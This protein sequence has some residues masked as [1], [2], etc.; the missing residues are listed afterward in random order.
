[1]RGIL[2][3]A[4]AICLSLGGARGQ[5]SIR[6]DEPGIRA[7]LKNESTTISVPIESKL[8][9]SVRANLSL[10]WI[11]MDD[12]AF[13]SAVRDISIEPGRTSVE[14]PLPIPESSLW[15]RLE[16]S[17]VPDRVDARAF[18][19]QS[20]VVALSQIAEHVFEL[21]A[22][23]VGVRHP[24]SPFTIHAQAVHPLTRLPIRG[25][26]WDARL[27]L[28]GVAMDPVKIA[29][30]VQGFVEISFEVPAADGGDGTDDA[31]LWVQASR[32]D[33]STSV[34]LSSP[35]ADRISARIQTDKP[36]YQPG[37]T[38]HLRAVVLD[39]RGRALAGARVKLQIDD[40]E[41]STEHTARLVASRFGVIQ[42]DWTLGTSAGLG[43]YQIR[44]TTE[45]DGYQIAN[46]AVRISRYELPTF[47]VTAKPDR[48]AYLPGQQ[49][50]VSISG[51]Y[52]FGKPVPRGRV[53]L[54]QSGG[55]RFNPKTRK[56]EAVNDTVAEGEAAADGTF[57]ANLDLTEDHENL[58]TDEN[59]RFEDL[60]FA[61]Y[62][63][64]PGSGRTEQRRFDVRITRGPIHIYLIRSEAGG[65]L[66]A[67]V[68]VSTDYADGAPASTTVELRY[69]GQVA[70]LHTNRYGLG[71]ASILAGR[72]DSG[73]LEARATD[74]AGQI[75][76]WTERYWSRGLEHLRLETNR[77]LYRSGE[78][79]TV[80]ISAP[81]HEVTAEFVMLHAIAGDR[82][83]ASRIVQLVD[84]K[85]QVTIP[86]QAEFRRTVVFV[87]WNAADAHSVYGYNVLGS[88]AVVFPDTSDLRLTAAAERT[89]YRPGEKATLR[90]QV[91][92]SDGRPVE[93]ALGLA[94]VD[95]AVLDRARTDSDFGHRTWFACA[96]CPD[97]GESEVGGIRLN[98][99]YALKPTTAI[100]PEMDLAAEALVAGTGG[101]IRTESS[102]SV[103]DAPQFK[104]VAS[105]LQ[106]M[107]DSLDR[108]YARTLEFPRD[109][110]ALAQVLGQQWSALRDPW[111]VRYEI[112]FRI[113]RNDNVIEFVSCGPDKRVG[114]QDDFVAGTLRRSYFAPLETLIKQILK[115]QQ[116]YPANDGE[117]RT[118]LS[119]NGLLLDSLRDPWSTPYR[120]SI[121]TQGVVRYITLLSAG[122]DRRFAS[123]DDFVAA[124]FSGRYFERE[125]AEIERALQAASSRPRTLEDFQRVLEKAGVDVSQYRDAW[126]RP[127]RLTSVRSSR[128]GDKF[129]STTVR[130]FGGPAVPRTNITPVTQH[131]ITFVLRSAGPDGVEDTYDDFDIARFVTLLDEESAAAAPGTPTQ[132]AGLLPGRGAVTGTISDPSGAV[133][134]AARVALIDAAQQSYETDSGADGGYLFSSVPTGVYSLRVSA[135]GF[136]LYEVSQVPVTADKA[137][138]VDI[139]LQVGAATEMVTVNAE[140]P[141]LNTEASLLAAPP[142]AT[143]RVREYFPETL[144]WMPEIITDSHGAARTQFALADSVTTWKVAAIASTLDGRVVEA[145]SDFRSFQPFFLDFNPPQVLTEGDRVDLPVTV[146]NYQD[147]ERK[148]GVNIQAN[149]WSAVSGS[150][151]KEL[152]VPANSSANVNYTIEARGSDDAARERI[153]AVAGH[154]RDAIEKTLR[155]HPDGQEVTQVRG[156]LIAGRTAFSV[157]IPPA[158][159][160]GAT[161]GELRLYPNIASM[162]LESAGAILESPHGCAEQTISAGYA[163][164]VALRYAR[165]AG[166]NDP[167]VEKRALTNIAEARDGLS[168]FRSPD[169]SVRYWPFGE[170]DIGVTAYALSFLVD[171]SEVVPVDRD[172][173]QSLVSWL[174]KEQ[175]KDGRWPP[176]L[177]LTGLVVRS[178]AAAQKT[179]VQVQA[180]VMA[181]AYHHIAQFTDQT[182]EP[183]LL[184]QFILAAMDSGDEALLGAAAP[185]LAAMAREEKGGLYWE[186][187]TNSPFYG[188]GTAGRFE[189][190]GLVVSALSAWRARHLEST[191]LDPVIR[192]GL[193]F[194]LRGRDRFGSWYST[195]STVRAMRAMADASA[196][197]GKFGGG[198]GRLEVRANGR[199]VKTVA[200]P[201]DPRTI[202]PI[203][204]DLSVALAAGDT[205]FEFLPS[206]GAQSALMRFSSTHWLPWTQTEARR[207]GELRLN[208]QFDGLETRAGEPLRC[209]VRAER[210]GF[211]GYGMMIAEIGL[212]PGAEVDRSSLESVLNDTS[213]GVN[214]YDVLPD[215]VLFYLWP[216]AG[217]AAFEF[218]LRGRITLVGKSAASVLYDYYNP[219][220]LAEV[221]PFRWVVK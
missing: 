215:R 46:H 198:G 107:S 101:F 92:S 115:S 89:V 99:L 167:R 6:I 34:S 114:T 90:M 144:L 171:A 136:K 2:F 157:T 1:M 211:R 148:V 139:E 81:P 22:T 140:A 220:A 149:A 47:N 130:V 207:S 14:I 142:T 63:T 192:R 100:S 129:D 73:I 197:L 31:E 183:Y 64:D 26:R 201:D 108:Y 72:D 60:H 175:S 37:Q 13:D 105:Q 41:N 190:T 206:A 94:V 25:V 205:R 32:G 65:E 70:T 88:K 93:A 128:Y 28:N 15:L 208:I 152:L 135:P 112:R 133:V 126:G 40:E 210:V 191:D 45:D 42:D 118:L 168:A 59:K 117:L 169:G 75:G 209:S 134:P 131:L 178:L 194:L 52:L 127:Y 162:L 50:R 19:T 44:L 67:P 163:N 18:G 111:G 153:T 121:H 84:G 68:Y 177:L 146:R 4:V 187:R 158:A 83:V 77:T 174:Q 172:D 147:R 123:A 170:P 56:Y 182:D 184:A 161:R 71:K 193:V 173:L 8:D 91:S 196:I 95:Q 166:I 29:A 78:P 189:T 106:Q 119:E 61:A 143:P 214:R 204:V 176:S 181:A 33:F 98:D 54:T 39:P 10:H 21:K 7:E 186:L 219:E 212:P 76:T 49:A 80:T 55:T 120:A 58:R 218:N 180:N 103:E 132:A 122:P 102:E 138:A 86:Y 35:A 20:G 66:P 85:G 179:G 48:A 203:I 155:V 79:V 27:T 43:T 9:H 160:G 36:I 97:Q 213:L 195:Q 110:A 104:M 12:G 221:P 16:Y 57:V 116:D 200:M 150:A 74:S 151:V 38:M 202:D 53:K 62:Y 137:T 145:E 154:N 17:L 217:G 159:I 124:T 51:A 188:W 96:F 113:E 165:A 23:Q 24:G 216:K 164:L 156:D 30:N 185:R 69:Q 87:A 125:K 82:S 5:S 199:L 109:A 141:A 3:A 11:G